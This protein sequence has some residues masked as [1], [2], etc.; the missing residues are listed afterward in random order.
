[1]KYY[2]CCM[3]NGIKLDFDKQCTNVQWSN[4]MFKAVDCEG[5]V[6]A[7][8]P[9]INVNHFIMKKGGAEVEVQ[10]ETGSN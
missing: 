5:T 10:K 1:M 7:I 6:L 8:I 4:D 3:E 2:I 9:I